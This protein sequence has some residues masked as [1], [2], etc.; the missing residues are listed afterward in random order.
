MSAH[1][2]LPP[3]S[4]AR[5]VQCPASTLAE[6][7]YPQAE[8]GPDAAD[9]TAAHWG[10]AEMLAGRLIDVGL[11]AP[12]GVYLTQEMVEAAELFHD[13]V[14]R[15][16]RPYGMLPSQGQIE[17]RV[18]IPRVHPQS[19]GT[20]DYRVWLP[21]AP[22]PAADPIDPPVTL[23]LLLYDFKFGRRIVEVFENYQLIE[24]V[25]GVLD[26]AGVCDDRSIMVTVK[27][28]QPRAFHRD[29]A[30]RSW[31]FRAD[32][33]RGHINIAHMAAHE[34]L[35]TEAL[36]RPPRFRVGPECRD[37]SARHACDAL[38]QAAMTACDIAGQAQPFDLPPAA[39]ALEY[40]TLERYAALLN[41]R[42]SGLEQQLLALGKAGKP[43]PGLRIEHGE[44]R[45]VWTVPAEAVIAIG[46]ALGV[47]VAQPPKPMTPKQAVKAG[48]PPSVLAGIVN[49]PRG[50]AKL[51]DDDGSLARRVFG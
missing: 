31:T 7:R 35:R 17:Q 39:M 34:A 13:D 29:G 48:L 50:E 44:G 45:E 27:I 6:Q 18:A 33:I 20:P 19:W 11:I 21:V 10:A 14:A 28:V 2:I 16:L 42:M 51:V 38:H 15:E 41:A 30:I 47:N 36:G 24:Y 9:G 22:V 23:H 12:N 1:S 8:E 32:E 26:E 25:A 46:A 43:L 5:R 49:T 40:R 3:S 37:C 4:A